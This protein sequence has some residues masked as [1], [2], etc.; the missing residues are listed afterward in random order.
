MAVPAE[1]QRRLVHATGAG[2][3]VAYLLFDLPWLWVRVA[4]TVGAALGLVLEALRLSG[5]VEWRVF[6]TLTRDYER[7]NL[8]GYALYLL[9]MAGVA[10]LFPPSAVEGAAVAGMLMLALGDP[11]SGL[12]GS[13]E[14]RSVKGTPVLVVMFV[15]CLAIAL[16]VGLDPV[17][18]IAGAAAATLADGVKP[19]VATY[20]IDDNLTIPPAAA[21]GVALGWLAVGMG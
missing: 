5:V 1:V 18:A 19:V 16:G 14:L 3:P 4:W 6:D 10:W 13:G 11:V 12:L 9:S 17:P 8:A 15:V 21:V 7:E 2:I 20:V